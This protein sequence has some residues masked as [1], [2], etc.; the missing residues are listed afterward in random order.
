MSTTPIH[1]LEILVGKKFPVDGAL[2]DYKGKH[3]LF[4]RP[5]TFSSAVRH[6]R[7][8]VP[9][10][11]LEA[12]E[13]L[14]REQCPE[15]KDFD[16]MLGLNEPP[17]PSVERPAEAP[18]EED[19]SEAPRRKRRRQVAI[20]AALLPALAASYALGRYTDIVPTAHGGPAASTPDITT[21]NDESEDG[22][23]NEMKFRYFADAGTI[24]CDPISSLEA[25]CTD[26][27]GM[28]MATKAAT[29]PD[30]T[31]FTFS[32]GKER[33]GLRVFY[34]TDYAQTWSRQDGSQELYPHMKVHG[35]YVLWGT[36]PKRI[37]DYYE[38]LVDADRHAGPSAMGSATPLPPR[39]AALT[40]GTLGLN[41]AQVHQI[42]AAPVDAPTAV[43][44]PAVMAARMVLGLRWTPV[45]V[46]VDDDDIVALAA[47][48]AP[49]PPMVAPPPVVTPPPIV[50]PV[51]APPPSGGT[52]TP[53]PTTTPSTTPSTPPPPTTTP[54]PTPTETTPPPTTTPTDPP[55]VDPTPVDPPPAD[56]PPAD[57]GPTDP[58]PVD[59]PP[60]DPPPADPGPTDP[61]PVDPPPADPG[62]TDPGPTDPSPSDP[63]PTDPAPADPGPTD[64][65]PP[66]ADA[67]GNSGEAP[68]HSDGGQGDDLLILNSAWTV[69]A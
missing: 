11:T 8:V 55:P 53:P 51:V 13:R 38:L 68:G 30:S 18:A 21:A 42:L 22:P 62:P 58:T 66:T 15:F 25:E 7:N 28:V 56:P 67:P 33:I 52:T 9:D 5:Q 40:L 27:D 14:V 35:R 44:A 36:D 37:E 34:D 29:G 6:V 50:V 16:D 46:P 20:V 65:A 39:L 3:T 23:F 41:T 19:P 17:A 47:G 45:A 49:K 1:K 24:D 60:A 12:A 64:P 2:V 4:L 32:Y 69:A 61:T 54:T 59:P 43:E 57:P 10:I 31:I 63:T 26:A 48:I